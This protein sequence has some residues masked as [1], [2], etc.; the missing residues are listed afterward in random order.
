MKLNA[1][2]GM[3]RPSLPVS[4]ALAVVVLSACSSA[5]PTGVGPVTPAGAAGAGEWVNHGGDLAETRYSALDQITSDNVASLE[6]A[7]SYRIPRM[8]ARLEATPLIVD[9]V[10]YATGP[11]SS[12][13]ALD[14]VS[15]D[16]LWWWDPAIP[17]ERQGGPRACCGDV[18][19]GVALYDDKIYVGLLDGRLVALNRADGS[20]A[21][22]VQTTPPG[23]DYSITGAPRVFRGRV[24]IGN[25]GAEYGVR[26]YVTAYDA[27]TG[28]Q[29][30]RTYTV[31]GDPAD[32]F[33]DEAM[34]RAAETWTGE[35]WRAGGGGTVW[36]AMAYDPAANLLYIGTGNGS[37]WSRDHRSPGGGDNLYLSS[38]VALDGDS[39]EYVWHYQTTPGD[40]W[41]YTA[42]QPLMLLDLDIEGRQR[43]V[44]VQAP[45]NGFFFVVDRLTG[46]FISAGKFGDDVTWATHVDPATGRPVETPEARYGMNKQ[47]AWLAPGPT[48]SHNWRPMA[49][50]ADTGLV[51]L[52][53]QNNNSFYEMI[54]ELEYTPGVWNTGTTLLG[55][56]RGPRPPRPA[57]TGPTAALK[58]WDPVEQREVW[59]VATA[60][61]N[62]GTLSTAGNLVFW[63][64]E[65][66]LLALDARTGA[67]LWAAEVGR[68]TATPVTY[69]IDGVQYLSVAG[70]R[71]D[72]DPPTVWTFRLGG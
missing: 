3:P 35:W 28:D 12:V 2:G 64:S 37:P 30:W 22:S 1:S 11:M 51:Y 38:I 14:A 57:L 46:E 17:A 44:I 67:E 62:G 66:R 5:S 27:E 41:D 31:P 32:G 56:Q 23:A 34:R 39:G 13:Y 61:D 71:G 60:G 10:M 8:G 42:T 25:G 9:G 43:P 69:S 49:W 40:D 54:D 19:R 72:A 63:G 68:G 18:N 20:I 58:A 26:G 70:G 24:V 16:Q 48:G 47:G 7:W 36:D 52:P 50:N 55:G 33:E 4:T 65:S 45:K 53:T 21:W 15:G 6:L 59:R 29:L